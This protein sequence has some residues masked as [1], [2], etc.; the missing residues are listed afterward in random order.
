[1]EFGVAAPADECFTNAWVSRSPG[2][3]PTGVRQAATQPHTWAVLKTQPPPAAAWFQIQVCLLLAVTLFH[4]LQN[5]ASNNSSFEGSC[6]NKWIYKWR[7]LRAIPCMSAV[8]MRDG[9]RACSSLIFLQF[10]SPRV[11]KN[12]LG[13]TPLDILL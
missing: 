5:G 12:L 7:V 6:E 10:F 11:R 2:E 9:E 1:M 13:G 8:S 4:H 3:E